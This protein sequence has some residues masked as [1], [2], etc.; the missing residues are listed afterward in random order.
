MGE[1]KMDVAREGK[2]GLSEICPIGQVTT[3]DFG[4][5]L[6]RCLRICLA[7][8]GFGGSRIICL[9]TTNLA[10]DYHRCL[11]SYHCISPEFPA[12]V[13]LLVQVLVLT[14]HVV[15]SQP[16]NISHVFEVGGREFTPLLRNLI[17]IT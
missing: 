3:R 2:T 16:C 5:S 7:T 15:S 4:L 9:V 6:D 13:R 10:S 11:V 1:S 12:H 17:S 8:K 14:P